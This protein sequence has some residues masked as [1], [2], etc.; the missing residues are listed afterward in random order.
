ML[1]KVIYLSLVWCAVFILRMINEIIPVSKLCCG[2][3]CKGSHLERDYKLDNPFFLNLYY[4]IILLM[5]LSYVITPCCEHSAGEWCN[6]YK[7]E[8]LWLEDYLFIP[9]PV[10]NCFL[11]SLVSFSTKSSNYTSSSLII[12][13]TL[14]WVC[15]RLH[16]S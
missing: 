4:I 7:C 12:L 1:K 9:L 5:L 16:A 8:P 10:W 14:I 3:H 11:V 2:V 15:I 13:L 6:F